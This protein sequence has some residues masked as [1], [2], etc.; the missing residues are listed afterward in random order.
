MDKKISALII[1]GLAVLA[2][3]GYHRLSAKQKKAMI[4]QLKREGKKLYEEYIPARPV[5]TDKNYG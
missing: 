3:Y 4:E 5:T 1:G 2:Y